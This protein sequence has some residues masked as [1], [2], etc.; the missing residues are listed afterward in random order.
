M[1]IIP[2]T[3]RYRIGEHVVELR[4]PRLADAGPWRRTALEHEERLRPAFGS[5][6]TD[7]KREHDA[8]AWAEIWWRTRT[9]PA[10]LLSRMV[11]LADGNVDRVVGQQAY[12]G[13]D[14]RTG[15]AEA[16]V[17]FAGVSNAKHVSMW[18]TAAN[19]LD[20]LRARPD[21]SRVVA[22]AAAPN[23]AARALA[24]SIGFRSVQ[25]LRDLREFA[26]EPMMHTLLALEN[27]AESR[28]GLERILASIEAE[29]L[30]ARP[31]RAITPLAALGAAR[32]GVRRLR[33]ARRRATPPV[34]L[35][36]RVATENGD[37]VAVLRSESGRFLISTS[38][39]PVGEVEVHV[40]LGSSTVELIDRLPSSAP[41]ETAVPVIVALC[42]ALAGRQRTRRLTIAVADRHQRATEALAALG[43][44]SEGATGPTLGDES[45]PRESWTRLLPP[46]PDR[47]TS[48][49]RPDHEDRTRP[50][51]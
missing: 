28:R 43:F 7:W 8:T 33:H 2:H 40:D 18:V 15:H 24:E 9:D 19:I 41:P 31:G 14:V 32:F 50:L 35:P 21:V 20:V 47:S 1:T 42:R 16:S 25:S 37:A 10:V 34:L 45:T 17:W 5:P 11:T 26:G 46:P 48:G 3:G 39:R 36:D 6:R 4:A 44:A 29:P 27:T 49:R 38:G 23:R 30:S 13:P 12:V 22:P 51:P